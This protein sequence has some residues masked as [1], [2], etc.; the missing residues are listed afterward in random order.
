VAR[1]RFRPA[2]GARGTE[3]HVQRLHL[4][5]PGWVGSST[6]ALRRATATEE[7]RDDLRRFRQVLETGEVVRSG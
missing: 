7:L 4:R 3:V 6:A 1:V 5:T 2:P